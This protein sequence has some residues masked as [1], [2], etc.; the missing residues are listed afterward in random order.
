[1]AYGNGCSGSVNK[2]NG[3]KKTRWEEEEVHI[4]PLFTTSGHSLGGQLAL[5][6]PTVPYSRLFLALP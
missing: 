1:M 6:E 3:T 2:K 4:D 5:L